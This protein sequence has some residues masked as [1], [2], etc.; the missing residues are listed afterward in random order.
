MIV[1][2]EKIKD[3]KSICFRKTLPK[4]KNGNEIHLISDYSFKKFFD[5]DDEEVILTSTENKNIDTEQVEAKNT[6]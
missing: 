1:P 3:K 5:D 6:I 4:S 2:I